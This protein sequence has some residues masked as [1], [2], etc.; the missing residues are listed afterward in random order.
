[1]NKFERHLQIVNGSLVA[2]ENDPGFVFELYHLPKQDNARIFKVPRTKGGSATIIRRPPTKGLFVLMEM[3][4]ELNQL[5]LS[6][7]SFPQGSDGAQFT[8]HGSIAYDDSERTIAVKDIV[9]F[10][11]DGKVPQGDTPLTAEML[12]QLKASK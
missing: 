1:M 12:V 10:M 2:F 5:M 6:F 9:S 11:R 4:L 8:K 3:H 7:C